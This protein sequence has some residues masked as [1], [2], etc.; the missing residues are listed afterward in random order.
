MNSSARRREHATASRGETRREQAVLAIRA[1][2][3]KEDSARFV[4]DALV[5]IHDYL[6]DLDIK[7]QGPPATILNATDQPDTVD[8]E[9][10]WPIPDPVVGAGR[11]YCGALPTTLTS[12]SRHEQL[13]EDYPE[14]STLL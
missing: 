9:V 1:Q 12:L 5:E 8:I 11:I 13:D 14:T 7:P 10:A 6:H 4:H 3:R 2:T